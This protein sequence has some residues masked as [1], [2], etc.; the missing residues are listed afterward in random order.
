MQQQARSDPA[1]LATMVDVNLTSAAQVLE[2]LAGA[3]D[4]E[5]SGFVCVVTSVAGDRGRASNYLYGATKAGLQALAS[6]LRARL[7]SSGVDCS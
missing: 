6:G 2:P 7:A 1:A 4:R 5:G 3:L